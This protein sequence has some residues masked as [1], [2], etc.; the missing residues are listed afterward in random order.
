MKSI[1]K[2]QEEWEKENKNPSDT[3][4]QGTRTHRLLWAF[5]APSG[6]PWSQDHFTLKI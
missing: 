5:L 2:G 3:R 4:K 6:P 1:Q